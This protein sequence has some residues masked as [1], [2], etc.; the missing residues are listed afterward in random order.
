L[1][2]LEKFAL[3][4]GYLKTPALEIPLIQKLTGMDRFYKSFGKFITEMGHIVEVIFG[5]VGLSL[6]PVQ[7]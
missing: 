1:E 2:E 5:F 3:E 6:V 7:I 4:K